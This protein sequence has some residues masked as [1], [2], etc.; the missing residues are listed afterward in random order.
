METEN[1]ATSHRKFGERFIDLQTEIKAPKGQYNDFGNFWYRNCEDILE[2]VKPTLKKYGFFLT[3]QDE[4]VI[5]GNRFY[6]KA[7]ATLHDVESDQ[8]LETHAFAR[9]P[10]TKIKMDT[11]QI[12]G[13]ASSYARK[14]AMNGLFCL[15]DNKDAD[16]NEYQRQQS[17]QK[18]QKPAQGQQ[19]R[20]Q[21]AQNGYQQNYQQ[22]PPANHQNPQGRYQQRSQA[23][24]YQ[25]PQGGY[26][27]SPA[28]H[29]QPAQYQGGYQQPQYQQRPAQNYQQPPALHPAD[30]PP[31]EHPDRNMI[32]A[33]VD[34]V[35]S[36]GADER[37]ILNSAKVNRLEDMSMFDYNRI[38]QAARAMPEKEQSHLNL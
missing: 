3:L 12:T 31:A 38:V 16:T 1:I 11:P 17:G 10:E 23:Q 8:T 20:Q 18:R 21:P 26:Q 25:Q 24:N 30:I 34:L 35:R 7:T 13:T 6:V 27:Q 4:M 19:R 36:K 33:L 37:F 9:E 2:A 15:D 28:N 32:T 5:V 14:Y 29:Q 22:R